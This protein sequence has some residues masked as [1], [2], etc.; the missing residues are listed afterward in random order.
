MLSPEDFLK[1]LKGA[2]DAAIKEAEAAGI[3]PDEITFGL[4]LKRVKDDQKENGNE[5]SEVGLRAM[6]HNFV[7]AYEEVTQCFDSINQTDRQTN[8]LYGDYLQNFKYLVTNRDRHQI[9]DPAL[10]YMA[11]LLDLMPCGWR[12]CE[13]IGALHDTLTQFS[14][15]AEAYLAGRP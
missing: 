4:I 14:R 10:D 15:G 12:E 5:L 11:Y 2:S 3:G 1:G 6:V 7:A 13:D 9:G 8:E